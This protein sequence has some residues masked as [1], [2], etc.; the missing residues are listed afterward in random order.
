MLSI[1]KVR[2]T[3]S[4]DL[5]SK[6]GKRVLV[7]DLDVFREPPVS[8]S[9]QDFSKPQHTPNL[10]ILQL[11]LV[12]HVVEVTLRV[13]Q[14]SIGEQLL[15]YFRKHKPLLVSNG[16][17]SVGNEVSVYKLKVLSLGEVELLSR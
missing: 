11:F 10:L 2:N 8:K 12:D 5:T 3:D 13:P 16:V 14:D 9:V 17:T 15:Y 7:P 1:L 4:P 6:R